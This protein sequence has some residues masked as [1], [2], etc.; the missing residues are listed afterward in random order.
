[1]PQGFHGD[2]THTDYSSGVYPTETVRVAQGEPTMITLQVTATD[3]GY[4]LMSMTVPV[5][6]NLVET[7]TNA[8]VFD[9]I[10]YMRTAQENK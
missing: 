1:M 3:S 7:N 2:H 8:P 5:V 9:Q 4:P 6:L 10:L